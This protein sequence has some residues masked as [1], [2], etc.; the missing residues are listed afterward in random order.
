ME[1]SPPSE[2]V[3]T[4]NRLAWRVTLVRQGQRGRNGHLFLHSLLL[5]GTFSVKTTHTLR[6]PELGI[7][8]FAAEM[9]TD[10]R[11]LVHFK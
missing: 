8:P 6:I 10:T 11:S 4:S 2:Q 9:E 7:F 3:A 5:S 1:G